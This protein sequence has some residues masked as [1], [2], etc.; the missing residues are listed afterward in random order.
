[1][2]KWKIYENFCLLVN[3]YI[4]SLKTSSFVINRVLG[5]G[6]ILAFGKVIQLALLVYAA[7]ELT[8][9]EFGAFSLALA[10]SQFCSFVVILGGQPGVTK[11]VSRL[12]SLAQHDE[13]VG[14]INFS[15]VLFLIA[16][17][18]TSFL[19]YAFDHLQS[20]FDGEA[21][22]WL[23]FLVGITLWV[24]LREGITRGL[25]FVAVSQLPHEVVA[26][27][28]VFI[29]AFSDQSF[30]SSVDNFMF[31]WCVCF[32]VV[33]LLLLISMFIR[34][35]P[36]IKYLKLTLRP[37]AWSRE[38]FSI[39]IAG[40]SKAGITRTDVL[41]T[42]IL[43]GTTEAGLYT[44]AQKLAQ[45]VTIL[46]RTIF[47][48]T[49]SLMTQYYVEERYFELIQSFK[50]TSLFAALGSAVYLLAAVIF[51][52]DIL[53]LIEEDYISAFSVF[54][55]LTAA[56]CLDCVA[57]PSGQF[58]TMCGYEKKLIRYNFYGILVYAILIFSPYTT[59]SGVHIASSVLVALLL[60][61]VLSSMK[62]V[63]TL[64]KL[65]LIENN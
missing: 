53:A 44:I 5:S 9:S 42:G 21:L 18:T 51:G 24:V 33:E 23:P 47:A 27:L 10:G 60:L 28:L 12:F 35:F 62:A 29:I 14:F 32:L 3:G 7:R 55:I 36:T 64:R 54:V 57:A 41:A 13:L 52:E 58:L 25:S 15:L 1:V 34:F 43:L 4:R 48:A 20:F 40:L 8:L 46:A 19:I 45:P 61:N 38:L 17:S 49:G 59:L 16:T 63:Q 6:S 11:I 50:I 39:Q 26:P 30:L 37:A 2:Q 65:S 22:R 31:L 56:W